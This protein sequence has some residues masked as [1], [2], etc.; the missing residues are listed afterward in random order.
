MIRLVKL[1]SLF[2]IIQTQLRPY[3][4]SGSTGWYGTSNNFVTYAWSE[5]PGFSK[6]GSFSGSNG[7]GNAV[8]TGFKP[9]FVLIRRSNSTGNWF[10]FDSVRGS[11]KTIWADLPDTEDSNYSITMTASGFEVNGSAAGLNAAGG[12]YI[13]AAWAEFPA[14]DAFESALLI[15]SS[16][17]TYLATATTPATQAHRGRLASRSSMTG[18]LI[19]M[20]LVI[21]LYQYQRIYRY[22]RW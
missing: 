13:Y 17:K 8:T 14:D 15:S 1:T 11:G 7:N 5:I 21:C 19:L 9:R 12:T 20:A 6:F 16:F 2:G 4:T 3:G 10:M 18:L 22:W